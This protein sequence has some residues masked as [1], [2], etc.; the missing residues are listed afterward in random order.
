MNERLDSFNIF[1]NLIS[2]PYQKELVEQDGELNVLKI[3]VVIIRLNHK[4]YIKNQNESCIKE[5]I[6]LGEK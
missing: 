1:S 5:Y 4:T 6:V 3:I 2:F